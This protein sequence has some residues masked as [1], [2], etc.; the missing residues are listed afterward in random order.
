MIYL[1]H[2]VYILKIGWLQRILHVDTLFLLHGE[3]FLLVFR[4]LHAKQ[5]Q[6]FGSE[7]LNIIKTSSKGGFAHIIFCFDQ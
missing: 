4:R 1:E 2:D 3:V 5:F 7:V 6:E